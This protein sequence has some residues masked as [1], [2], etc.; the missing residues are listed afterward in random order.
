MTHQSERQKRDPKNL[1]VLGNYGN[2][3][4]RFRDHALEPDFLVDQTQ[5]FLLTKNQVT[6]TRAVNYSVR[7]LLGQLNVLCKGRLT[8]VVRVA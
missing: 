5:K 7:S 1:Q 3:N 8:R 4:Y 2:G 6:L